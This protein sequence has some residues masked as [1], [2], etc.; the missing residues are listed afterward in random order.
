M[1]VEAS[2]SSLKSG[3]SS[4][5]EMRAGRRVERRARCVV[6]ERSGSG[7]ERGWERRR[8]YSDIVSFGASVIETGDAH[9]NVQSPVKAGVHP[10][11][12]LQTT[13]GEQSLREHGRQ[14]DRQRVV[15]AHARYLNGNLQP[16]VSPLSPSSSTRTT[17][18]ISLL[19][20][21]TH[22]D[23]LLRTSPQLKYT[24]TA[25]TVTRSRLLHL[26]FHT[27]DSFRPIRET[28]PRAAVGAGQDVCF[29][30]EGSEVCG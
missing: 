4:F 15:V 24:L 1:W 10:Q 3:S 18:F 12:I 19:T 22:P 17:I 16:L 23:I 27:H 26:R 2:Q 9:V 20:S 11:P 6:R 21:I 14:E 25:D 7:Y 8:I 13:V 29:C 30:D 5:S 28:Y